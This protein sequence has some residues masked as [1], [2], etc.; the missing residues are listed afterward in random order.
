MRSDR[1]TMLCGLVVAVG[2]AVAGVW[3]ASRSAAEVLEAARFLL[4]GETFH[5]LVYLE[6]TR[7]GTTTV[8]RL[9]LW[10][11]G[12]TRAL[13]RILAPEQ[14]AG[15][16]YLLLEEE[17]W[18]YAPALGRPIPLPRM[19]LQEGLFGSGLDL[20]DVLRGTVVEIYAVSFAAAQ[21]RE[22]YRIVLVPLPGAATVYGRLEIVLRADLAFQEVVYYDQR[23]RVVKTARTTEFLELPGRVVPRT[24]VVEEAS[25]DRTVQTFEQLAFDE[26]LD[27]A[28]FSLTT[29]V[30]R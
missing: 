23:G 17:L 6:V 27:P 7:G 1:A 14:D 10:A 8:Y 19:A 26:P 22:G 12:E 30:G 21:P 5:A 9:E 18:Y 20:D 11:K 2:L 24:I 3:A 13:I 25:G 29:L 4:R 16:G 15:S 28:L